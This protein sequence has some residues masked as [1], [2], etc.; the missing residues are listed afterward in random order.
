[1]ADD[2]R[3]RDVERL[4]ERG[5]VADERV[6]RVHTVVGCR[7]LSV[8]AQV[9]RDRAVLSTEVLVLR[10]EK[11]SVAAPTVNEHEGGRTALTI[12]V[13][14]QLN[15]RHAA[16]R[17]AAALSRGE[18]LG[19]LNRVERGAL[20]EVVVRQEQRNPVLRTRVTTNSTDVG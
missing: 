16:K 15:V 19:D 3:R 18:D 20:A 5:H 11:R 7:T 13:V 10:L 4:D 12:V 17:I 14:A 9:E 6:D 8:A 1:M 2:D